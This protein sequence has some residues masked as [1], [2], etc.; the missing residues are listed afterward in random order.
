MAS[1]PVHHCPPRRQQGQ[2]VVDWDIHWIH[3]GEGEEEGREGGREGVEEGGEEERSGRGGRGRGEEVREW[4]R[5][6]SLREQG[7][8]KGF[9]RCIWMWLDSMHFI[10]TRCKEEEREVV[11]PGM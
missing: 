7:S 9:S 11:G 1:P 5:G 8:C 4:R 10:K 6:G 3:T 2:C